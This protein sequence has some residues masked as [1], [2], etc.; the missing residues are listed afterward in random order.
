MNH[1]IRLKIVNKMSKP[2]RSL[3]VMLVVGVGIRDDEMAGQAG[4][5]P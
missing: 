1:N 4:I 3:V 5:L 2:L